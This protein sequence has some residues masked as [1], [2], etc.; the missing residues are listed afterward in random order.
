M[1]IVQL[2]LATIKEQ[3]VGEDLMGCF[4]HDAVA[5]VPN[6]AD[7]TVTWITH[8]VSKLHSYY[9]YSDNMEWFTE[10][11]DFNLNIFPND[12]PFTVNIYS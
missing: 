12:S 4:T 11:L 2:Q 1:L 5:S 9:N 7:C 10:I 8:L 6:G 3:W